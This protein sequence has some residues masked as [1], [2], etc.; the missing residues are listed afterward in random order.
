MLDWISAHQA[1]LSTVASVGS[2][3]IW[4]IYAQL[5]YFGF[6]RQRRPRLI[7]NRGKRKGLEALCVISNMSA[8]PVYIQHI[9]TTLET[10]E[11]TYTMDVSDHEAD[12]ED[13]D[14]QGEGQWARRCTHQGPL[15]SGGF[16]HI[17]AFDSLLRYIAQ[18]A[19]LHADTDTPDHMPRFEA[20]TVKLIGT[21]CSEDLPVGAERRFNLHQHDDGGCTLVPAT[22]NTRQLSSRRQRRALRRVIMRINHDQALGQTG[23]IITAG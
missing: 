17:G 14:E 19:G 22:W 18:E 12:L 21:Y 4:L 3:L 20:V 7:I 5:L 13:P 2:F 8:E 23:S 11:G 1:T 16:V 10:C 9:I 6:R 15:E